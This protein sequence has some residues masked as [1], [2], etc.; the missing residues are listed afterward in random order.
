MRCLTYFIALCVLWGSACAPEPQQIEK[1]I[2]QYQERIAFDPNN[3]EIHY[4]LGHAHLTL[5]RYEQG[6]SHLKDAVRLSKK[7][8]LAHRDLGWALYELKE[9]TEA[10]PWLLK[11]L[12]MKPRDRATLS[13]LSAVHIGQ[14]RHRDAVDLLKPFVDTG[15]GTVKIHNNLAA[16][17][18]HL[19]L[20]PLAIEQ[21][22]Q[23][24][25]K[26]PDS[27]GSHN[28]L[29][30]VLEKTGQVEQALAEYRLA[31]TLDP[32][33]GSAHFNLGVALTHQGK[34][35]EALNHFR[36]AQQAHP[37]DP[38]ILAG[39]GWTY[40]KRNRYLLAI[41]YYKESAR[42]A[43]SN[44]QIQQALGELW[45]ITQHYDQAIDA[46]ESAIGLDP[47]GPDNYYHLGRLSDHLKAGEKAMAYMALA[48]SLYRKRR[49]VVMAAH[50][51]KNIS[52]LARKYKFKKEE[53]RR[54][55]WSRQSMAG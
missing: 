47:D 23:A 18:R 54:L 26:N 29:G 49:N 16:A 35:D 20:Y 13:T 15:R 6:A 50:C 42:L 30:V 7:H 53:V 3:T 5:G 40:H 27:A 8:A 24:L 39:L 36:I 45:D 44:L 32:G 34:S 11:A 19:G 10:E 22:Q 52:I 51:S 4:Q 1:R 48:E 33:H 17:Y 2:E 28:N 38:E 55:T 14:K 41:S 21:L 31:L 9:Y 43:P 46:Y 37:D 12:E 25:K